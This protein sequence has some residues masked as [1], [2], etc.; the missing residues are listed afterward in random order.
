MGIKA[1]QGWSNGSTRTDNTRYHF[2]VHAEALAG[3]IERLS[4]FVFNPLLSDEAIAVAIAA[5]DEEFESKKNNDW[6]NVLSVIRDNTNPQ[7]SS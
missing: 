6:R 3:G 4:D 7:H 2:Q 1:N 5:V